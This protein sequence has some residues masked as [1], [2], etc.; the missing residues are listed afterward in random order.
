[1][2]VTRTLYNKEVKNII[3]YQ[4]M[5]TTFNSMTMTEA[6][7]SSTL[8]ERSDFIST[9][10]KRIKLKEELKELNKLQTKLDF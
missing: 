10:H 1:M 9:V 5:N 4:K 7:M 8:Y 3:F 6:I 2:A